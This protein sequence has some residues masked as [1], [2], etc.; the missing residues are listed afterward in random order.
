MSEFVVHIEQGAII[1]KKI[2]SAA[3]YSLPDGAYTVKIELRRKMRT[4][5]Q[6][7]YYFGI[8]LPLVREGL[9]D[10]GYKEIRTIE[11]A[12]ELM[13]HMFLKKQLVQESTG[14]ALEYI[15]STAELTTMQFCEFIEKIIAWGAEYLG[16]I[17]PYPREQL[18][19]D[20]SEQG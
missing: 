18:K 9:Q 20:L 5:N 11:Q 19:M 1:N 8:C 2:V 15:G 10:I 14:E 16:I 17:I 13:K 7:Q 6:N 12:H 3:F 4:L